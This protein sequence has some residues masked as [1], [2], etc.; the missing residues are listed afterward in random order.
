M[1]TQ[2]SKLLPPDLNLSAN[3]RVRTGISSHFGSGPVCVQ[4]QM[5]GA[6]LTSGLIEGNTG[7]P[8]VAVV[9][10]HALIRASRAAVAA[11]ESCFV[12]HGFGIG[13]LCGSVEIV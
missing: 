2:D 7:H 4:M 3:L 13:A 6:G 9:T 5:S 8:V 10:A 11:S 12:A 1:S